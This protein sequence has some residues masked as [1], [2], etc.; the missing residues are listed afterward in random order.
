MSDRDMAEPIEAKAE[1]VEE[2]GLAVTFVP[3]SI[4]A[5]FAA[6]DARVDE[7]LAGYEDARYDLS[8]AGSIR[9]AKRDRA[10]LNGIAKEIDERRRAVKR[11]Y[12][13][14]YAEFEARAN[15][16]AQKVRDA[17]GAIK[18]QLDEAEEERKGAL[19]AELEEHYEAYAGLLAPVVPYERVHEDRWLNKTFGVQKAEQA[20]QD[21]VDRVA[22][23]WDTLKAQQGMAHYD[24][25]ERTFFETLDLGEALTAAHEADEADRRI[26]EMKAG[27]SANVQEPAQEAAPAPMP[28]PAPIPAPI[29]APAPAPAA[30]QD[31]RFPCVMVIEAASIEQ[32]RSIGAF[33]AS[34]EPRVTGRFVAGTIE[35]AYRKVMGDGR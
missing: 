32:M 9:Q 2:K 30:P 33:A 14:P 17:S 15:A 5:N 4:E 13:R 1:V 23:D 35:Q 7:M 34:L 25:A 10:Y 27:V 16:I 31:G 29:A 28:A 21:K 11:E 18:A 6:L 12:M 3:A 8:D 19:Y 22:H 24:L 20:I 26:E